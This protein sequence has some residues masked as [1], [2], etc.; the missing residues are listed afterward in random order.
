MIGFVKVDVLTIKPFMNMTGESDLHENMVHSYRMVA[1][2]EPRLYSALYG[3][4]KHN[5]NRENAQISAP[6]LHEKTA[7]HFYRSYSYD[8]DWM[9]LN[10]GGRQ[11]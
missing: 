7:Y 3:E 11:F 2:A 10:V 9:H 5:E 8:I 1:F 6:K 4:P